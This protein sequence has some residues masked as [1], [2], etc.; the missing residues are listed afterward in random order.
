MYLCVCVCDMSESVMAMI[1]VGF[2]FIRKDA[3]GK[4]G[5]EGEK[6]KKKISIR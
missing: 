4:P 6:D 3:G 5:P 1:S 2:I